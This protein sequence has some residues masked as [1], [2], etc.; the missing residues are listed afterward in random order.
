MITKMKK[1]QAA[2][3]EADRER[4][5]DALHGL[6][7]L[8]ITPIDP[9]QAVAEP[10]IAQSLDNVRRAV[11]L[12]SIF[13]PDGQTPDISTKQAV[14]EAVTIQRRQSEYDNQLSS[15]YRQ[16]E[17][18]SIWNDL[19]LGDLET[20]KSAGVEPQF[21]A[22]PREVIKQVQAEFSAV[23]SNASD[24]KVIVAVINRSGTP[25]IPEGSELIPWPAK[26]NP[27]IRAEAADIDA[28][29]K[30]SNQR[31]AELANLLPEMLPLQT[32]LEENA[33]FSIAAN[34][35]LND[36]SIFAIEGWTPADRCEK[37]AADLED[38]GVIAAIRTSEPEEEELP[39]TLIKY[40][41]WTK[42]IKGLFDIL[43]T[44]PGYREI[45]LAAF[46]MI[47]MPIFSAMLIGDGGYGL[48]FLLPT[49]IMYRKMSGIMGREGTQLLIIMGLAALVWGILNANFFGVTPETMARAGGFIDPVTDDANFDLMAA[50]SGGW[51][52]VG[53]F[54]ISAAPLWRE[55]GD[56]SRELLIQISF[57]LGSIHLI[58]A[59][60]RRSASLLPDMRGIA[61]IG[62]AI[63]LLA[64]L[65]VI[66]GM[67]FGDM[68]IPSMFIMYALAA[69]LVL[70]IGFG[71]PNRNPIKRIA[72]GFAS[73][74]LPLIST[75]SD[76]MSYI[77]LM[78]VGL[79]SYYIA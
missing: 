40:P 35:A 18:Q 2:V 15:L 68:P 48:V 54:M 13:K 36:E 45:D 42:P 32:E 26:D 55:S 69:G 14:D 63:V 46:F 60:I 33:Q 53:N 72:I 58:V 3:V 20:L 28:K 22:M 70:V 39:P 41:G 24:R 31:L 49:V 57:L 7:V 12:L 74:L 16:L 19:S 76:T 8:H 52:A 23:I 43:N 66:W 21:Y 62:W 9:S 4:L 37:L 79:A 77:R 1:V 61:E 56:A 78:A 67:F 25:E 5:L 65:G 6:G 27:T 64:M 17:Q 34:S 30:Q 10:Q 73:S 29:C 38:A 59:H 47:A 11:Q 71:S 44:F 50:A 75:F 51:A